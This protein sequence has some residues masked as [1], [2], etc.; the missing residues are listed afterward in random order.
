MAAI[1]VAAAAALVLIPHPTDAQVPCANF[2]A[3]NCFAGAT[4]INA[5]PY[6]VSQNN[7][8]AT[9][10]AG[11]PVPC[12]GMGATVWFR[13][14]PNASGTGV[15]A[16][17]GSSLDTVLAVYTG[18]SVS[19]LAQVGYNDN[20]CANQSQVTFTCV[21]GT[22][23]RIQVGGSAAAMGSFTMTV[24][25]CCTSA[26]ANDCFAAPTM[27]A[28]SP[29]S[30]SMSTVGA[31]ME[32]GEP[33]PGY[34]IGNTVWYRWTA[35]AAGTASV[36]TCGSSYDT[37]LAAWTGSTLA[38]L[39]LVAA[40]DD[41]SCGTQ[42]QITFPCTAGTTYQIQVSRY[43][44][45]GGGPLQFSLGGC[46][47]AAPPPCI[48]G[49]PANDCF[50]AATVI[51]VNPYSTTQSPID[52][53]TMET[54]EQSPSPY[55]VGKTVW[56]NWTAGTGG[57]ATLSTCGSSYDT[58]LSVWTGATVGTTV[59]VDVD[60]DPCAAQSQLDIVCTASTTYH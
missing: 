37:V 48:G 32:A 36:G 9:T 1:V 42:S 7:N 3:N 8:G 52:G 28:S 29:Y 25:G 2:P 23:Y 45:L 14:T 39:S 22:T 16:T 58:V 35:V 18:G 56:F 49:P 20:S 31:T 60:D 55:T 4:A 41:S 34:T 5:V 17:C 38:T 40:N 6:S 51:A 43:F 21:A 24:N 54:G 57:T 13:W 11:E 44:N 12:C 30:N 33:S 19:A 53:A 46:D 10:E 15:V 47:G 50:A 26:V 27:V 59:F